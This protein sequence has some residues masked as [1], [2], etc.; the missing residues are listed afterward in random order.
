M[1]WYGFDI[2]NKNSLI[3]K[4]IQDTGGTHSSESQKAPPTSDFTIVAFRLA[5]RLVTVVN[6]WV[7]EV[8]F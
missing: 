7:S 2:K 8:D 1:P 3:E 5:S 4:K 6:E